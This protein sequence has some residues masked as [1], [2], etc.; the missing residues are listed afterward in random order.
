MDDFPPFLS[1]CLLGNTAI[2]LFFIIEDLVLSYLL[3]SV[4]AWRDRNVA[5]FS[6][7]VACLPQVLCVFRFS[8]LL[9]MFHGRL[10]CVNER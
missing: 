8:F 7:A 4:L 6:D 2:L 3:V 5:F 1:R 10:N 9:I